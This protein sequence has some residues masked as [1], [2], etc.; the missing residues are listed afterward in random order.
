MVKVVVSQ[1]GQDISTGIGQ[2]NVEEDLPSAK[3]ASLREGY[4]QVR[5]MA[6]AVNFP[7]LLMTCGGYQYKPPVPFTPGTEAAGTVE[8]VGAGVTDL[9]VGDRV[10]CSSRAG[11]M[12]SYVTLP[13]DS[14]TR[15]S[16]QLSFAQGAA[17]HVAAITAYHCLVERA[18]LQSKDRVLIAGATGGVGLAAVQL[19]KAIGCST[20]IAIGSSPKKLEAVKKEGATAVIDLSKTCPSNIAEEV[21][22]L[23]GGKGVDVVYD[24]VGGEVFD[25][26]LRSTAWGARVAI[27]GFAGGDNGRSVRANYA[28]IKGLS[29]FGCRAGE[30]VR[31]GFVDEDLRRTE[32]QEYVEKGWM[33][34]HVSHRFDVSRVREAF[35]A[36][37]KREVVGK[38]VVTFGDDSTS[39]L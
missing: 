24:P 2:L 4:V 13:A 6:A 34:P 36:L 18:K 33:I 29:I 1:L 30:A 38:C 15:L 5:V 19:T 14:C 31:Q 28:L 23:T 16:P 7:D 9:A 20:V 32:L 21:K 8:R 26:C 27:V 22:H 11:M 12:Q 25:Q 3:D 35:Q 37:E 39:K 17:F 10:S